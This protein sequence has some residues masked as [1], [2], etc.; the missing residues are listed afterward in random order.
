MEYSFVCKLQLTRIATGNHPESLWFPDTTIGGLAPDNRND[1]LATAEQ[2]RI[3]RKG[4]GAEQ[5]GGES[6]DENGDGCPFFLGKCD[7][8]RREAEQD[9]CNRREKSGQQ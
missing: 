9:G 2:A 7:V 4:S 5:G 3:D 6:N 8:Q 1:D